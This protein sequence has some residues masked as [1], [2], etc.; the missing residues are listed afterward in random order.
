M[1]QAIAAQ[2]AREQLE[3]VLVGGDG[4]RRL[5]ETVPSQWVDWPSGMRY[6]EARAAGVRAARGKIVA[7]LLDHCY[8]DPGWAEALIEA[9]GRSWAAVGYGYQHAN[10]GGYTSAA[11]YLAN[12]GP[13]LA[14]GPGQ[15]P[16]LPG[17][18]LSYR[19]DELL[20]LGAELGELLEIDASVHRLL[21][22]SGRRLGLEP[23]ATVADE[24]FETL[25]DSCRSNQAYGRLLAARRT[26]DEK[27]SR[28]QRL[29]RGLAAPLLAPTV[30]LARI[31]RGSR[32]Q[33][34]VLRYVPALTAICV[35]WGL[36]ELWGYLSGRP[37]SDGALRYWELEAVR[38]R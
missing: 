36:G 10:P 7:F 16:L 15:V 8:P 9:H 37:H 6:G 25:L 32:K 27:L 11:T 14:L 33:A 35:A 4:R 38:A 2:S 21:L 1:E 5:L 29:L 22:Q 3:L 30:R 24:T 34:A 28:P 12:Y 23:R 26:R 20:S 31:W 17:N 18:N 19:R 13:W